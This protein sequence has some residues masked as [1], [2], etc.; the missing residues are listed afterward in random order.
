MEGNQSAPHQP[1]KYIE[2]LSIGRTSWHGDS[3]ACHALSLLLSL[4]KRCTDR[5]AVQR[6]VRFELRPADIESAPSDIRLTPLNAE[7][8]A[9]LRAHPDSANDAFASGLTFWDM[10]ARTGF[11]W[12][13]GDEP[14]CFQWQLT[15][16][17]LR[18]LRERSPWA[19]LY[20]PLAAGTAQREKLW[21]FSCARR[22]GL[23]SRFALAMLAEARR[24]GVTTLVT[25]VS[26]TNEP[27]LSLVT[28]AGWIRSGTI[29]RYAFD[30]P[31]LRH[32]NSSVAV[33]LRDSR[34]VSRRAGQSLVAA[35]RSLY[36]C[37]VRSTAL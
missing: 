32:L 29:D 21:T 5:V 2:W 8:I 31:M 30:A 27:A 7:I 10:G 25:H 9:R 6:F 23:A 20:P 35:L 12:F 15:E 13:D 26:E 16:S 14:L 17:D 22:K 1:G 34:P 28:K 18:A 36:S 3:F 24:L 33:H 37:R 11:V 4:A 19:N